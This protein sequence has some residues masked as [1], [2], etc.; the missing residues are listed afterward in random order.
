MIDLQVAHEASGIKCLILAATG[1]CV[2][3][4]TVTSVAILHVVFLG[5]Q[6]GYRH[7]A[8]FELSRGHVWPE[9]GAK[10]N[11]SVWPSRRTAGVGLNMLPRSK[12]SDLGP[13]GVHSGD[14]GRFSGVLRRGSGRPLVLLN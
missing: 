11:I 9:T 14:F 8:A 1:R 12:S 10:G 4:L 3:L 5:S 6:Y 7:E 2:A 13:P